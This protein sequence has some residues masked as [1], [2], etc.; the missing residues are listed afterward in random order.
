MLSPSAKDSRLIDLTVAVGILKD[1]DPIPTRPRCLAR[2]LKALCDP[3]AA[4][5]VDE[6][7][8][9]IH[10]VPAQRRRSRR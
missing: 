8:D 9:R 2:V 6:H 1:F 5:L 10:D 7:P 3:V 4:F